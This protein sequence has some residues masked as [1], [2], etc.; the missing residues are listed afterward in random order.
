MP[1]GSR[2]LRR[3]DPEIA[4]LRRRALAATVDLYVILA[5][6]G[7]GLAVLLKVKKRRLD[8]GPQGTGSSETRTSARRRR[9]MNRLRSR[10]ARFLVQV[11]SVALIGVPLRNWRSPGARI[12]GIRIVDAQTGGAVTVRS[13]LIGAAFDAALR[14]LL[15][16][17]I[18][19]ARRRSEAEAARLQEMAPQVGSLR[20]EHAEDP[21]A[22][23]QAITNLYTADDVNPSRSVN[24]ALLAIAML[25]PLTAVLSPRRQTLR[26]RAAGTLVVR[27]R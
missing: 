10:P 14:L 8:R 13:V 20:R 1:R 22:E 25:T 2:H 19:P 15:K 24:V 16:P 21:V 23:R 7:G 9:V 4:S 27:L 18:A 26:Q 3:G 6:A 12:A 17:L 11:L 5:A